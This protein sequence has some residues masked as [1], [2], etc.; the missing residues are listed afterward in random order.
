MTIRLNHTIVPAREK[1]SAAALF[2]EI[3]GVTVGR[4]NP[5]SAPGRFAV[6]S[7]GEINFD[8]DDVDQ[9]EPH[10]YAFHVSDEEFDQILERVK[11]RG[12]VIAADPFYKR[13]G[14]LNAN[15][16]GRGFYFRTPDG[17]NLELLTRV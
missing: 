14:E 9:F 17:H 10:H 4:T 13:I 3:F 7:I 11:A 1:E 5:G 16:G 15:E 8:F 2:A 6:V 12:L